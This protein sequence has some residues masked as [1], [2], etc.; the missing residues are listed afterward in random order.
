MAA[1][2]HYALNE[3]EAKFDCKKLSGSIHVSILQLREASARHRPS[4]VASQLQKMSAPIQSGSAYGM[5][6]EAE[7]ART[8]ARV[9]AFNARLAEKKCPTYDLAAELKPGNTQPPQP[10]R[11]GKAK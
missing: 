3:S 10:V 5:D 2:G 9:E 1:D 4:P 6:P 8:R 11:T 7:T